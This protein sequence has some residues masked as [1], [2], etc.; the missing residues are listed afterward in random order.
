MQ[1]PPCLG[2]SSSACSRL[3]GTASSRAGPIGLA[4]LLELTAGVVDRGVALTGVVRPD[5]EGLFF[6]EM[7]C[8]YIAS[9]FKTSARLRRM[10]HDWC[11]R[12]AASHAYA[13]YIPRATQQCELQPRLA[14]QCKRQPSGRLTSLS[15]RAALGEEA[16]RM[17]SM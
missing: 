14:Q 12:K 13:N 3:T 17:M 4:S 11:R 15:A 10:Q 2:S 9:K 7:V 16:S 5:L 8:C 1:W 6:G